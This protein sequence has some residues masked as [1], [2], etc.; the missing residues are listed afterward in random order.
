MST[1]ERVRP[2]IGFLLIQKITEDI[3]R[4]KV[5]QWS[6]HNDI[7]QK[8]CEAV[9]WR[10]PDGAGRGDAGDIRVGA[11]DRERHTRFISNIWSQHR[12]ELGAGNYV[13]V[14]LYQGKARSGR[15]LRGP[16]E[17]R[18]KTS[19]GVS[20]GVIEPDCKRVLLGNDVGEVR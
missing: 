2:G 19:E 11:I 20:C 17:R 16:Q 13:C 12:A 3:A 15:S 5:S 14:V 4:L 18:A 8:W 7:G 6:S 1:R 9:G 10:H